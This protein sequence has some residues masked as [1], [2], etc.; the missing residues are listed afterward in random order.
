MM[1]IAEVRKDVN[2][3][4]QIALFLGDVHERVKIL[5]NYGQKSLAYLTAKTHGLEEEAEIIADAFAKAD[6][7]VPDVLPGAELFQPPV[8]IM[9]QE[10]NWPLL[11]VSKGFFEGAMAARNSSISNPIGSGAVNVPSTAFQAPNIDLNVAADT[12]GDDARLDL[13]DDERPPRSA[14]NPDDEGGQDAGGEKGWDIDDGELDIPADLIVAATESHDANEGAGYFVAPVRGQSYAQLFSQNSKLPVDHV[15]AGSFETAMRLLHDQVGVVEFE[16]Y[17][18]IFLQTYARSKTVFSGLPSL[19][20]LYSYPMRNIFAGNLKNVLPAIGLKL[21]DLIARLQKAYE[22]TTTGRFPEAVD[23]FRGILLSVPLLVVD[24]KQEIA[25]AQQLIEVCREYIVGLQMELHRKELP[26]ESLE[27]QKRV[28]ELAAYFTHCN[29]QP[30]HKILTLRTA[31]N[32]FFKLKNYKS[33][34]VFAQRLLELGPTPEVAL[35]TRKV[36]AACER[37]P[38]NA[39]ELR[40][41]EYNPFDICAASYLPI[42]RGKPVV[43]CPL[44]GAAYMPDYKGQ[45]CRVTKATKI[46]I[47]T[48]GLRISNLQFR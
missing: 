10:S 38:V 19:Q 30:I 46:G 13:D 18:N 12:W 3:Q 14:D 48:I 36:L 8:P 31:L 35:Q 16:E 5:D 37:T 47:D 15:L 28:C 11:S 20:P 26:K 33:A 4:F 44:S 29:L 41:D 40:Y 42:Y 34:A 2:G 21:S 17:K 23:C 45:L 32:L 24:S 43:K 6:Q 27:E 9:Q 25:E 7:S 22:M 39:H 1:K